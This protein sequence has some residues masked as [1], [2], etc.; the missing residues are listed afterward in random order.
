MKR[1]LVFEA[2]GDDM[3]FLAGGTIAKFCA[4]GHDVTVVVAT[5]NDKGSFE[6][7]AEEMRAVRDNELNGAARVLGV[8]RMIPLGYSDGD[9]AFQ[10]TPNKLRGQF[11]RIIRE[12]KPDIVFTWDPFAPNEG[13]ADHRAVAVAAGEA[14]SFA[15]F[16]LYYPDQ[17]AE[18][19]PAHYVSEQ[20][21]FSKSAYSQNKFVDIDGHI[22]KKILALYQ[23]EAQMVLTIADMQ[24]HLR[25][26]GLSVPWLAELDPHSYHE[27]IARRMKAAG[28]MV[29]RQSGMTCTYAEG[30]RRTRYGGIESLAKD[31][32][33]PED[34]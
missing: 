28:R 24:H 6:Q 18:G 7:S 11:M 21:F 4:L 31:Q 29:A 16:P 10:T 3:E 14:A 30:F 27:T 20:W 32:T 2:H 33:L 5:D 19:L 22:E 17:I 23:H 8:S 26:S 13:H 25:A 9:L 12:V 15:H 1:I 34:V